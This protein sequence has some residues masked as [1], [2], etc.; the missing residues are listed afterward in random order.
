MTSLLTDSP[1]Q[2]AE[3]TIQRDDGDPDLENSTSPDSSGHWKFEGLHS[4]NYTI[5]VLPRLGIEFAGNRIHA[6]PR[7]S[8]DRYARKQQ[9]VKIDDADIAGMVIKLST[10]TRIEGRVTIEGGGSLPS[11]LE[12]R[13][14]RNQLKNIRSGLLDYFARVGGDGRFVING[15]SEGEAQFIILGLEKN[16]LYLKSIVWNDQDLKSVPFAISGQR[17]ITGVH[18]VLARNQSKTK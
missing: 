2:L 11:Q 12:V 17:L 18:V 7:A 13:I 16:A 10:G 9:T 8:T 3:L 15:V 6:N 5:M 4:G 1:I 14:V